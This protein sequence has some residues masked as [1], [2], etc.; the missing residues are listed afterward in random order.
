MS[1]QNELDLSYLAGIMDGE[2]YV[3]LSVNDRKR[4]GRQYYPRWTITNCNKAIID[5]CVRILDNNSIAY[6]IVE[7]QPHSKLHK[8]RYTIDA[9]GFRRAL[10]GLWVI[11]PYLV[12]KKPQ[13]RLVLG[14]IWSRL[15]CGTAYQHIPYSEEEILLHQSCKD[16]NASGPIILREYMPK[17]AAYADKMYSELRA[18][19][20]E[21]TETM[22]RLER[23]EGFERL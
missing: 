2:G 6:H 5:E 9:T 14:F 8:Y 20:V 13:A 3:G 17:S 23:P 12:G 18:K 15:K 16:L 11:E 21:A 19:G 22:A 7:W 4:G 10:K 1:H